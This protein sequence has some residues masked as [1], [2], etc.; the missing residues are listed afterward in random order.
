MSWFL[1]LIGL[2]FPV[3]AAAATWSRGA[4]TGAHSRV[5]AALAV[6][7]GVVALALMRAI[8]PWAALSEW[9]WWVPVLVLAG[10]AAGLAW[11]WGER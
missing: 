3:L 1:F 8:V 10:A 6:L 4:G 9:L 7:D 5:D 11:T 2:L